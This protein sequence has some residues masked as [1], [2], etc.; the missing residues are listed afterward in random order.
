MSDF[1][2]EA[3]ARRICDEAFLPALQA[4]AREARAIDDTPAN[5]LNGVTL[6][7]GE[8]LSGLIGVKGAALLL[9]GYA[10]HLERNETRRQ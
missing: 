4:A 3:I 7:F 5:L 6:A 1:G 10:D 9:R 8:M 2:D